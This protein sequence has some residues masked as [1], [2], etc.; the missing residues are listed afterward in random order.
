MIVRQFWKAFIF[1]CTWLFCLLPFSGFPEGSKE[2]NT[3]CSG[4]QTTILYLCNNFTNQCSTTGGLRSQFAVYDA[5]QSATPDNRLYFITQANEIVYMGFKCASPG[6]NNKVVFRIRDATDNIVVPEQDLPT[7]STGYISTLTQACNGPNQTLPPPANTG[8][9]AY[10]WTPGTPGTFYIEFSLKNKNTGA[11]VLTQFNIDLFDIT[12]YNTASSAIQAGRLYSKSWQFDEV[13][14]HF[15][16]VNYILSDD[17]IV[18]STQF[19]AMQGGAWIQYANQTGCGN[20]NWMTDRKSLF[21]QQ[22]LF[23]QYKIFLN[24]P[25]PTVFTIATTLG[26]IV[27]P[28]P[29]GVR[30]CD[31]TIN[32]IV[33]VDKTG[34]VQIDLDFTPATYTSRTLSMAVVAGANTIPWDGKDGGGVNVPNNANVAFTVKYINGLTNLPL[35]DVEGNTNGFLVSLVAPAG[36]SPN[37]FWDDVNIWNGTGGGSAGRGTNNLDVQSNVASGGCASP[38]AFPGCHKW[39]SSGNGWGNLN[40]INSW[41]Y[42]VSTS[43]TYPAISEWRSPQLITFQTAPINACSGANNV[44][45]TVVTEP[46]TETYNWGYTGTGATFVPSATTTTNSVTVNFAPNATSGNITVYGTNTNCNTTPGP[47]ASL[48]VTILP[49]PVPVITGATSVCLNSSA[50]YSTAAGMNNYIWNVTGGTKTSGGTSTDNTVTISWTSLGPQSVSVSYTNANN[51]TAE[52]PTSYTVNVQNLPVP[53]LSGPTNACI[54]NISD[55]TTQSGAT[56]YTWDLQPLTGRTIISGGGAND[57]HIQVQWDNAG[58]YVISVNYIVGTGCT[59]PTPTAYNV[60]VNPSPSPAISAV[61]A[62]ASPCGNTQVTYSVG[63]ALPNH[64]YLWT[65]SGGTPASGNGSG[66]V[67]TWGNTNPVSVD[68][69]ESITY[70]PGVV[71]SAHAPAFPVTLNLIPDAAGT[72]SGPST[73]CQG[74]TKTFSVNTI[75]NADSYTWWYTPSTDV[76]YVN[77]G[78]NADFTFGLSSASGN[79]FVQGNKSGCASGSASPAYAITIHNPP[80]VTLTGCNDPATTTTSR[81]FALQGGL[82]PGTG[83]QYFIDGVATA[84]GIFDPSALSPMPHQITYKFTDFNSCSN[85]SSQFT[86]NVITGSSAGSCP[87]SFTDPRDSRS[88]SAFILGSRCW[89]LSNL[90]YGAKM[91]SDL[92]SQSDNCI[93][94][95]YCPAADASCSNYGGLY[96]WDELIQYQVPSSVSVQGLCPP[97]WHIPTQ[98]EWQ[99]LIDAIAGMAYGDGIAGSYLKDPN[100][101]NGFHA[102]LDGIYYL[103]NT[104]AF[105]SGNQLN[106]TIFWTSTTSGT[107]RAIARGMNNYNYSVSFYPSSRANA[108]PV[109]CVKD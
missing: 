71:C 48:A 65:I 41:W 47:P 4:A 92:Q 54:G 42:T 36:V 67:V 39:P 7:A 64:A 60:T 107:S 26:Q 28:Y 37:V 96:Q 20:T 83:G 58:P 100:Q 103:N 25:D 84:S 62:S 81:S 8:Y 18:T 51:C 45:V 70:A 23:P 29:Y 80:T 105:T 30:N 5:T 59:A 24:S 82:P 46:N 33:N 76:T 91:A 16:G 66:I 98:L 38:S 10:A 21:N 69:V 31:G 106:S 94:E 49:N 55:Y 19:S 104:W 93:S 61:P 12:I 56:S 9:D 95:K 75:N 108:F 14:P 102:L 97:E 32:F 17:G 90:N 57:D 34:N 79:L 77:N 44:T 50:I 13:A 87:L 3:F 99:G 73:V 43:T 53:T 74:L 35:Y 101:S 27:A 72:I 85:T 68:V 52:A 40:T 1:I 89:M 86:I 63:A 78:N 11:F 22:A 2:L 6:T 88:Y 15:T 109:R